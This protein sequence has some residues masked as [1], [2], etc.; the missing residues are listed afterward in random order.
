V[1]ILLQSTIVVLIL[2]SS[3]HNQLGVTMQYRK[4]GKSQLTVSRL[5]LGTMMF[6]RETDFSDA[7]RIVLSAKEQ[8][9][10]FID[11]ADVYTNGESEKALGRLLHNDRDWWVLATK[12]GQPSGDSPNQGGL[13]RKWLMHS[14]ENSLERLA[15]DYIDIF[16]LHR[17][18][19]PE[20]L[21]DTIMALG[22][23]I[24]SG[25]IRYFGLSNF[26]GWRIA[27]VVMLCREL[28]V[29]QPIVCQPYYNAVNRMPEVEILAACK[30]FEIGVVPYSPIARGVLTGKY[31]FTESPGADTRAGR[32]DKRMMETEFRE[33]SFDIAQKFVR[34][35]ESRGISSAQFAVAWVLANPIV[36]SV[37]GGPRTFDQWIEYYGAMDFTVTEEDEKFVDELI[38]PGHPSTPGYSD[39]NY[40]IQGRPV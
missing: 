15:T 9:V 28:N 12:A 36:S 39:P 24:T 17:D 5:C 27:E 30:R 34:Y 32:K 18:Y 2:I 19:E 26:R 16:Y 8:G 21:E 4:L 3:N 33:E 11:T 14:L 23:M 40:P 29:P 22:D 13:S 31:S 25:K 20:P 6:G 1:K 7:S 10:N 37:I 38:S 35:A